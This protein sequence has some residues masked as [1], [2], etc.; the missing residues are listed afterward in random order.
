[1]NGNDKNTGTYVEIPI[2]KATPQFD[3]HPEEL[4]H[5]GNY[6]SNTNINTNNNNNL[7]NLI[8]TYRYRQT[9]I[10][11]TI[12]DFIFSFTYLLSNWGFIIASMFSLFGII[13]AYRYNGILLLGY[14]F[15]LG[16]TLIGRV[17]LISLN[18][19][20]KFIIITSILSMLI[21]IY[22]LNITFKFINNLFKLSKE[23]LDILY[24]G[25]KPSQYVFIWY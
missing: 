11:F 15:Y 25:W 18:S 17:F 12:L 6:G 13:G 8:K 23:Q 2:N 9:L 4:Y 10:I 16:I 22:V 21:N 14:G 3:E 7:I 19:D 20:N 1:M 5:N 24:S